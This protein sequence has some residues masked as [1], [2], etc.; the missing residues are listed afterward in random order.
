MRKPLL[1]TLVIIHLLGNTELGE[2]LKIPRLVSHYLQHH[3]NDPNI[4]FI[5]FITMHY[6]N[7]D[8]GTSADDWEDQQLPCHNTKQQHSFAQTL[9]PALRLHEINMKQPVQ[10][11]VFG[12]RAEDGYP[13]GYASLILQPPRV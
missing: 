13:S 9:S 7:G 2:L 8:D 5:D 10:L 3:Y 12:I 1:I 6:V 4:G 11:K